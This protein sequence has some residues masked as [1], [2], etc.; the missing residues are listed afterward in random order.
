M[1][2]S[3]KV[4]VTNLFASTGV[5]LETQVVD[6]LGRV[7]REHAPHVINLSAGTYTRNLWTSLGFEAFHAMYPDVAL[8]A[9]AGNDATSAPFYPAA[10]PWVISAGALGADGRH[11]AWFS[12]YGPTVDVYALGEA[13]VNAYTSGT[14]TYNE[15]P[16]APARQDFGG[17]ARWSGTSFS[18]PLVAGLIA[19]RMARTGETAPAAARAVL[20]AAAMQEIPGVGPALHPCD[21]P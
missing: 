4:H 13:L 19:S 10:Y 12:N 14:Y 5:E 6:A 11:R 16:R 17:M 20:D 8:V 21:E 1:A 9:A 3:A 2:P 18:A 7:M 15:P